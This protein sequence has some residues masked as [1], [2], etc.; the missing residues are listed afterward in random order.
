MMKKN[1]TLFTVLVFFVIT[2]IAQTS[3]DS[4][5]MKKVFGGYQYLQNGKILT[6][7]QLENLMKT[8]AEASKIF[9]SV[10]TTNVFLSILSYSGGFCVGYPIGQAI[11]GGDPIWEMAAVGAGLIIIAIPIANGLTKKMNKAVDVYNGGIRSTSFWDDKELKLQIT[12]N[13]VGLALRF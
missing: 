10:K 3:G 2:A 6:L 9:K 7:P 8:N 5:A 1:F 4:I 12:G 11:G 13:G